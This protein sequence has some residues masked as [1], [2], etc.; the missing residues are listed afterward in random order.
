LIFKENL[1]PKS[2]AIGL[3]YNNWQQKFDENLTFDLD[4]TE[5]DI[6]PKTAKVRLL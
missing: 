4:S 2:E 5:I 1:S 3:K 6:D